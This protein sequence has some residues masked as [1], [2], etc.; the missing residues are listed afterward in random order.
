MTQ[1]IDT[2]VVPS[3]PVV[4]QPV[5]LISAKGCRVFDV[6][7]LI[8]EYE[9]CRNPDGIAGMYDHVEEKF[10]TAAEFMAWYCEHLKNAD[11]ITIDWGG[12]RK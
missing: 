11:R 2:G 9:P 1:W 6:D 3:A 12:N 8:H 10:V 4:S 5:P 7:T